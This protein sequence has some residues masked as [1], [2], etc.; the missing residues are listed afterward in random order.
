MACSIIGVKVFAPYKDRF[1]TRRGPQRKC[2]S[3]S[4]RMA[5]SGWLLRTAQL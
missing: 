2:R 1:R 3:A 4:L 5:A